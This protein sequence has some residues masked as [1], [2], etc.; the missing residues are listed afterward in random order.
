MFTITKQDSIIVAVTLA[1]ILSL[2]LLIPAFY[3]T[4]EVTLPSEA[5]SS[6]NNNGAQHPVK[7]QGRRMPVNSYRPVPTDSHLRDRQ[8]AGGPRDRPPAA[9]I[10]RL[11]LFD[12]ECLR[13]AS[14]IRRIRMGAIVDV[15]LLD[16]RLRIAHRPRG[17]LE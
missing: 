5:A 9:S 2:P 15:P 13:Y 4:Y 12:S 7:P 10:D 16:V 17:V 14:P 6:R 1:I 3:P 11:P 8:N